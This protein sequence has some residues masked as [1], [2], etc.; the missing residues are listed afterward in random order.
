M[1]TPIIRPKLNPLT[2]SPPKKN[3]ANKTSNVVKDVITVLLR[4]WLRERFIKSSDPK[5]L[6]DLKFSLILSDTT[7]E[8]LSE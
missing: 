2:A 7:I 5:A 8:S 6:S 1:R 3:S 4:V